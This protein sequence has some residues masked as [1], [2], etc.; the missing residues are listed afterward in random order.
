M[1]A[2][3]WPH[4]LRVDDRFPFKGLCPWGS[5]GGFEDPEDCL[6]GLCHK[7]VPQWVIVVVGQIKGY[8][9]ELARVTPGPLMN[10]SAA[11]S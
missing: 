10:S 8:H 4:S 9:A 11:A 2:L 1:C 7:Q 5:L 3:T 6:T